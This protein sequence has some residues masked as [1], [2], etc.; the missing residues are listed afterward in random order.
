MR[1]ILQYTCDC[2]PLHRY[3]SRIFA[4]FSG[5]LMT[6]FHLIQGL[7]LKV[8]N[9][10][11]NQSNKKFYLIV[12]ALVYNSR[13]EQIF[14]EYREKNWR[15]TWQEKGKN[16]KKL[17]KIRKFYTI[18]EK[19]IHFTYKRPALYP[20]CRYLVWETEGI[21]LPSIFEKHKICS[22]RTKSPLLVN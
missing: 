10:K 16:A 22:N 12:F 14:K 15:V 13:N 5:I 19:R 1:K 8:A 11:Y 21:I 4:N 20:R 18:L 6:T 17:Q 7:S 9:S 2:G 3:I